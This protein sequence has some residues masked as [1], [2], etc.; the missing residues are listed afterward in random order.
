[1]RRPAGTPR[2]A[3]ALGLAIV[4]GAALRARRAVDHGAFLSTDERAYAA[5][6]RA[7]SHGYYDVR[8]MDDPLHWP[9]GTPLL[10]ALARQLTGVGDAR[11]DPPETYWAQWVVGVAL[12]LA[13]F[14]LV[15]MLAGPW[16]AV[17][18]AAVVALYPPLSV[19]TGDLV[20]EPLGALTIALAMLGLAWAWRA[21][22]PR[23]FAVAGLLAGAAILVRADLLVLPP[24][25]A[26]VVALGLRRAGARPALL[27]AGA[28]LL[29]AALALAP[30]SAYATSRRGELTPVTSSSWSGL[31]V[32]TYLPADGRI[33]R[34]R[35]ALGD[36]ARAYNPTLRHVENRNLRTE[37]ILD[38]VAGR[39]PRL[40]RSDALKR[41]TLRNLRVYALG[42]PLRFAGMQARKLE[43]MWIGYDRGTHHAQRAWVLAVHLLVSAAALGGLVF[44]LWRTR[45][46]VLGSILATVLTATAVN[47]FFVSE[48]R[49]NV[50]LV[51]LLVAGGAAGIAL[52]L[53]GRRPAAR[54]EPP[55]APAS[56]RRRARVGPPS[57][58]G[59]VR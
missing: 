42:H 46:P 39:H 7:L 27:A 19:I 14:A 13:V 59:A 44:G 51:P 10:Y 25:L 35:Q 22:R 43:R 33:F 34:L 54:S 56:G 52:G 49:H 30:W 50:R 12:I 41:E 53:S 26:A 15:R 16:P 48:A 40:G 47:A 3:I 4:A 23:R 21:P 9:P 17:A 1:V 5:L 37:W 45:H 31:F 32:G 6:G 36:E 8:G 24:V 38:A 58:A 29:A 2:W 18:A 55:R 11:L 28:Y 20:S 57:G